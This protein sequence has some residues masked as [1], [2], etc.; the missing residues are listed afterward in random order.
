[1]ALYNTLFDTDEVDVAEHVPFDS[2]RYPDGANASLYMRPPSSSP[3][4]N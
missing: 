4:R 3:P 1:M 2:S